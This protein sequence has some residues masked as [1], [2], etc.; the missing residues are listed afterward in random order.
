MNKILS[1]VLL[2]LFYM[3]VIATIC[4]SIFFGLI[5][6]L[7]L[8]IGVMISMVVFEKFTKEKI[9]F[10]VIILSLLLI[11]VSFNFIA[12]RPAIPESARNNAKLQAYFD[13][14]M[15]TAT[16]FNTTNNTFVGFDTD[17]EAKMLA[18]KIK[19]IS[20]NDYYNAIVTKD[21]YCAKSKYVGTGKNS[22][23]YWCIDSKD[24][25]G[26]TTDQY[27]TAEKPYCAE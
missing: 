1:K 24:Y 25:A 2:F 18:D 6:G 15:A 11:V 13:Q 14:L 19:E 26:T 16:L 8:I 3:A 23:T 12:V 5:T 4:A 22:E 9:N 7:L 27:C 10:G 20:G 21:A 17:E